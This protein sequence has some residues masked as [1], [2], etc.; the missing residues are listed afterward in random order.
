MIANILNNP[1]ARF[2]SLFELKLFLCLLISMTLV[3][4]PLSDVTFAKNGNKSVI[5]HPAATSDKKIAKKIEEYEKRLKSLLEPVDYRY[6]AAGKPDPFKPFLR[7]EIRKGPENKSTAVAKKP[8]RCNTA[9]ECMDV[10]QL[11]LVGVVLEPNGNGLAMAQDASG[12]GYTLKL[13]TRIGFNHGQV[14]SITRDRVVVKEKVED[15][16]GK[17]TYRDRI[18]YL[19]PEEGDESSQ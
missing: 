9:L 14:V 2:E 12:I 19:H 5:T 15:L 17:P 4:G 7:T 16:R 10:G 3:G 1:Y 8:E 18:L 13:G 6:V 11:T